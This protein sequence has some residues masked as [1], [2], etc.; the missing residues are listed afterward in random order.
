MLLLLLLP[1]SPL[2]L[3]LL[4]LLLLLLLL[5][6]VV[7]GLRCYFHCC[8]HVF[9]HRLQLPPPRETIPQPLS[10]RGP[11]GDIGNVRGPLGRDP[12]NKYMYVC[13]YIYIYI[14]YS[15]VD[16]AMIKL[17]CSMTLDVQSTAG[18]KEE[19]KKTQE[20]TQTRAREASEISRTF[21]ALCSRPRGR[22]PRMVST[23][24]V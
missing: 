1:L 24:Y 12:L 4:V 8:F 6:C 11:R 3:L 17:N 5:M 14:S 19:E 15:E 18:Q 9:P 2:L 20:Q 10:A 13:I 16:E 22:P 23:R 7:C 21:R